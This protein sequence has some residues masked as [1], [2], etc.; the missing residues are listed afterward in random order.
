MIT[1]PE[2]FELGHP[3]DNLLH[4]HQ[5][6]THILRQWDR[7][8]DILLH[9]GSGVGKTTLLE[10]TL[11]EF[12]DQRQETHAVYVPCLDTTAGVIRSVLMRLPGPRPHETT[13]QEDLCLA[14][15]ERV[16]SPTI[17]VLDEADDVIETDAMLR[18]N[19]VDEIGVTVVCHKPDRWLNGADDTIRRRLHG[20]EF[21]V[22]R[23]GT[24]E[25]ADILERRA[26][27]GLKPNSVFH[28]EL[29]QIA[30]DVAGNARKGIQVFRAAAEIAG[31][32]SDDRIQPEHIKQARDRANQRILQANLESLSFHHKFVYELIRVEAGIE[33]GDVYDAYTAIADEVYYGRK[34]NS[35]C[36]RSVQNKLQLLAGYGLIEATAGGRYGEYKVVKSDVVPAIDVPELV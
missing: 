27:A 12:R 15:R 1:R 29:R 23:F 10:H 24:A 6:V 20:C 28:S 22:E 3:P 25:L 32:Q 13:P 8:R 35:L 11:S 19:D 2:V 17:V 30:D 9:G 7:Q 16:D 5:E 31:E 4:R 21:E 18:L 33:K 34:L 14:L 36:E 26:D